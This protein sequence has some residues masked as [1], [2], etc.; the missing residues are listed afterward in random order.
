VNRQLGFGRPPRFGRSEP[1]RSQTGRIGVS[2]L[3]PNVHTS[4]PARKT[5]DDALTDDAMADTNQHRPHPRY[6]VGWNL[7]DRKVL[8][9]GG[10][11]IGEG[12]VET[13][14]GTG[15]AVTVVGPTLTPRLAEL[16]EGGRI[17]WKPRLFRPHDAA[18]AALVI[19]AT[20]NDQTNIRV[21]RWGRR[22]GA[23][24][25]VVDDP[26]R[27][28]VIVPA[29]VR[30]GPATVA[31]T[32]D[33][34]TPAGSR[35]VRETIEAAIPTG[36]G[37]VLD[38]AATARRT[39]RADGRY[40]Y[41]YPAWRQRFFKP[42]L[43]ATRAGRLGGVDELAR[44]F[45]AEFD[46]ETPVASGRVTL[47]G[48]GPGGA[49]LITVAGAKA[50]AEA[51]VVVYD[52]L[53]DPALLDLAPVVAEKIPVGKAKGR[54]VAQDEINRI[55][56]DRAGAG[57]HV[58]RL[59]GGDPLVFGRGSEEVA[60]LEAN[61]IPSRV[62]PGISSSL[63]APALAGIPVTHR[64][65]SASF[66]VLSGHRVDEDNPDRGGYN[67]QAIANGS[68]TIVV[69]MAATSA[70][71]VANRLIDGGRPADEPVA[72]CHRAGHPDART[73]RTTLGRMAAEGSPLA[74]PSVLV[75]GPVAAL[76][77]TP[78]P[79]RPELSVTGVHLAGG[80]GV[81][82]L[83]VA[84]EP[85]QVGLDTPLG[86]LGNDRIESNHRG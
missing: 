43:E 8:I 18:R 37:S 32:T 24:V 76:S 38:A 51:D 3:A 6:F 9:V 67:W 11:P 33:G 84:V 47:V 27:C 13:L 4:D 65:L 70:D 50:L 49:E 46:G 85:H 55:L 36:F 22:F 23:L 7:S 48:A 42:G 12:K 26:S 79:E 72:I 29:V 54:G 39:L 30:R 83:G 78:N 68:D 63:A 31:I 53:A 81:E 56:V 60:A 40:R 28:D 75:I 14:L 74:A 57:N 82:G 19:A 16:A 41:D 77:A 86:E 73:A 25:N 15:A 34:A 80:P 17:G 58:V 52:R 35:F 10:G 61:G 59:K 20:E 69:L 62:V 1:V 64:E 45:L 2:G 21:A 66:T 71:R 5:T 44:R